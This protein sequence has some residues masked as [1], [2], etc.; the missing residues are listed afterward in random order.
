MPQQPMAGMDMTMAERP[1]GIGEER[2][3]SGTSWLPDATPMYAVHLTEG[4]WTVMIHGN[5]FV[6]YIREGSDRGDRQFGSVNWVMGMASRSTRGGI[7]SLR[8]MF[9]IEPLTVGRCGY[10]DLLATGELCHGVRLHDR[11]HPHDL[12]MELAARYQHEI[13]KSVAYEVYGGP[14]GEPA[15]GPTAFPHRVSAI[16]NPLS[17]VS[18]H[19]LDSSHIS[20][21]VLTGGVYGHTWKVEGSLFNGREPDDARYDFDFGALESYS[22]RV[23]YLPN[24]SWAL[25]VSAG[26]LAQAEGDPTGARHDVNRVTASATYHRRMEGSAVWATTA[27]WGRNSNPTEPST[28]ALLLETNLTTAERHVLFARAEFNRKTASDLAL[29]RLPPDDLFDVEKVQG[30]YE[31]ELR[32]VRGVV[33]AVGGSVWVSFVPGSLRPF[34]GGTRAT[35][36]A[37]FF[38]LHA[39]PMPPMMSGMRH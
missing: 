1:L 36:V 6:Q 35:G 38:N 15:L 13:T 28:F 30:G 29:P 12:F 11:Q 20:F 5:G 17:P 26:H 27:G 37:V 33:P 34:Y 25:Q 32:P 8:S 23:W 3:G 22:G 16:A 21:G 10:P 9:S 14:A 19:W 4:S 7:L 18:H 2:D 24:E 31:Y 39:A